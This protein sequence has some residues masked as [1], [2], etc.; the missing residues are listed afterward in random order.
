MIKN[1]RKNNLDQEFRLA[2]DEEIILKWRCKG[3]ISHGKK[4]GLGG[5]R[6]VQ[7]KED[8]WYALIREWGKIP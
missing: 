5:F 3:G 6:T 4:L 8:V 2:L 7:T 1:S